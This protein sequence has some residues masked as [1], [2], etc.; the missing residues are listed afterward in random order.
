MGVWGQRDAKSASGTSPAAARSSLV[1]SKQGQDLGPLQ[2]VNVID[3]Y[4][5]RTQRHLP[6]K[7]SAGKL[8][9]GTELKHTGGK[10]AEKQDHSGNPPITS[11]KQPPA[12]F[13]PILRNRVWEKRKQGDRRCK[14]PPKE[15]FPANRRRSSLSASPQNVLRA[16]RSMIKG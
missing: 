3:R 11:N 8:A 13:H 14:F 5:E 7:D 2:E 12:S 16:A 10:R 9:W 1:R 15:R 6:K 4:S